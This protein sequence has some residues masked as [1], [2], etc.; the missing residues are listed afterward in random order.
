MTLEK[1]VVDEMNRIK[2]GLKSLINDW[3]EE[4]PDKYIDGSEGHKY[5]CQNHWFSNISA[6]VSNL[7]QIL[8]KNF[9]TNSYFLEIKELS[10]FIDGYRKRKSN[11]EKGYKVTTKEDISKGN[12]FIKVFIN[13]IDEV[14]SKS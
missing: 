8:P 10:I 2:V 12:Y 7:I 1:S 14:L 11:E 3:I 6:N 9:E 5:K 4:I 13:K